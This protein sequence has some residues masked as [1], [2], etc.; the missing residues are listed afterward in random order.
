M[1]WSSVAIAVRIRRPDQ[2]RPGRLG[3]AGRSASCC[4]SPPALLPSRALRDP[5]RGASCPAGSRSPSSSAPWRS[6][7]SARRTRS[8]WRTAALRARSCVF[9]GVRD[10]APVTAGVITWFGLARQPTPRV[11]MLGGLRRW[12]SLFPFTQGGSDANMS[13]ASQVLIFA[14]TAHGPE[15]RRRPGRP[16]RPRLRRLPRRRRLRRGACCPTSAFATIDWHL[17][18]CVVMLLGAAASP[19]ILGLIIGTPTL[20]VSRRLPGHRHAGLR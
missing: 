13:I 2:R 15:H 11:L 14:A 3:L 17:P 20:R 7:C 5:Q 10:L 12:R 6:S 8:A 16:A 18:F 1:V 19:R 9:V 4:S